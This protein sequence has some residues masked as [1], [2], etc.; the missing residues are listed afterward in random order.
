MHLRARHF[1]CPPQETE[2]K[3]RGPAVEMGCS[4]CST[5]D[6]TVEST[7]ERQCESLTRDTVIYFQVP[8]PG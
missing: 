1:E 7:L 5:T 3:P 4:G 8:M 6:A 2:S